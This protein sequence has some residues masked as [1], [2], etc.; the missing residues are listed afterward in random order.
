M[1]LWSIAKAE[2]HVTNMQFSTVSHTPD[3]KE[4]DS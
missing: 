2:T 3:F 1:M 4:Y